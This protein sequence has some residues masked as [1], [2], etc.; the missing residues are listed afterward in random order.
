MRVS[1]HY[2]LGRSQATL[3]FVDVDI[4]G[5]T[6][7]FL[8]PHALTYIDSEWA[9][10]CVSLLQ[11]FFD[12]VVHA[13]RD[14][15]ERHAHALL[16]ALGEPAET[17][18]GL[19]QGAAAGRGIGRDLADDLLGALRGSA[20]V[21]TGLLKD[22]EETVLLIPG[23]G[24]DRVSDLTTNIIRGPL[25]RFTQDACRYYGI[26]MSPDVSSGR[27]WN[28]R[29]RAFGE[30]LTELPVTP[31]GKLILV[32]NSIVRR[33]GIYDPG[34]YYRYY[35]LT[36]LQER[37]LRAGGSLVRVLKDG[38]RVVSKQSIERRLGMT[39][40]RAN[41]EI[42]MANPSLLDEYRQA[43]ARP[44][45]PLTHEEFAAVVD[46]VAP[47][48]E[49]LLRAVVEVPPGGTMRISTTAGLKNCSPRC[50]THHLTSPSGR[51]GFTRV[52]RGSTSPIPTLAPLDSLLGC[53]TCRK[54]LAASSRLSA[55]TTVLRSG[56][57]NS[58]S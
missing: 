5:D 12:R 10:E 27:V 24:F 11:T 38:R 44:Q 54:S 49:E 16:S 14:G 45:E 47:P 20:A 42:T 41:L 25:I 51:R 31:H 39:S 28:H 36:L 4:E 18:L 9:A 57:R 34:E 37:E 26:P 19:S 56:I 55:R 29:A 22:L 6:R 32:P 33:A 8:D 3:E 46:S 7:L 58:T 30:Y 21:Q 15:D 48:W 2:G 17:H 53:A 1:Q 13:I 50:C 52:G 40:K 43:K 35:V 23:I